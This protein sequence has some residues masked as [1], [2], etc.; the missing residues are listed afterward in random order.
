M[1]CYVPQFA[2]VIEAKREGR[3]N[4]RLHTHSELKLNTKREARAACQRVLRRSRRQV[5]LTIS[6]FQGW[7]VQVDSVYLSIATH[8][9]PTDYARC[10]WCTRRK[11]SQLSHIHR[12]IP[13]HT[14]WC[15]HCRAIHRTVPIQYA[16]KFLQLSA[17]DTL[18]TGIERGVLVRS[19]IRIPGFIPLTNVSGSD[20]GS[21]S[22][23]YFFCQWPSRW[24]LKIIFFLH[25]LLL[26][27]W[28]YIYIIF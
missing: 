12:N 8:P 1:P 19:W 23:D 6:Y 14:T 26:T 16:H 18:T 21:G 28:S 25:F 15:V 4:S 3:E 22:G 2:S 11:L 10:L 20:S 27:F 17:A 9:I 5:V 13:I 24:Q 7:L